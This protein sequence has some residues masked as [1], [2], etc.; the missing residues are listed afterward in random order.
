MAFN[1]RQRPSFT[2]ASTHRGNSTRQQAVLT[3]QVQSIDLNTAL[4]QRPDQLVQGRVVSPQLQNRFDSVVGNDLITNRQLELVNDFVNQQ[5]IDP[6]LGFD[7]GALDQA[8]NQFDKIM[9][10]IQDQVLYNTNTGQGSYTTTTT[11]GDGYKTTTVTNS[12]GETR[13][14]Y[15]KHESGHSRD[16]SSTGTV[17]HRDEKGNVISE[18]KYCEETENRADDCPEKKKS[19]EEGSSGN[20]GNGDSSEDKIIA[21]TEWPMGYQLSDFVS[22]QQSSQI[23]AGLDLQLVQTM[24]Q[25]EYFY[26]FI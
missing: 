7:H 2:A 19:G 10:I 5:H 21:E 17:T 1:I 9:Q 11:Q 8:M 14:S 15:T 18:E 12:N 24:H 16:Q 23:G 26:S 25:A 20:N 4:A 22:N 3:E 13:Q 6:M